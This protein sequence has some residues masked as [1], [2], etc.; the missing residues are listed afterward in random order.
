MMVRKPVLVIYCCI[1][2]YYYTTLSGL[3]IYYFT[4]S[5]DEG[6]GAWPGDSDSGKFRGCNQVLP[7][8]STKVRDQGFPMHKVVGKRPLLLLLIDCLSVLIVTR[9]RMR[10]AEATCP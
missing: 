3:N 7:G 1:I 2:I 5:L 9:E 4:D 6:F 8:S 10:G